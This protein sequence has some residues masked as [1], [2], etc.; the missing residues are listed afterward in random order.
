MSDFLS[1]LL[2]AEGCGHC[3]QFRGDGILKNGK[4]YMEPAFMKKFLVNDKK[5]ATLINIHF[6][7]MAGK[8]ENI[9]NVSKFTMHNHGIVEERYFSQEGHAK[10]IVLKDGKKG[11]IRTV[12]DLIKDRDGKPVGW[13]DYLRKKIPQSICNYSFYFPCFMIVKKNN[14]LSAVNNQTDQITA[15]TNAGITVRDKDGKIGIDK[16]PQTLNSKNVGPEKMIELA[17]NNQIRFELTQDHY[18]PKEEVKEDNV[19]DYVI[20]NYDDE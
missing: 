18:K 11:L 4:K 15:F 7:S 20:R 1:V 10:V 5:K 9:L 12:N 8:F 6:N 16:N 2:T 19:G 14:W 17:F 3:V 13:G